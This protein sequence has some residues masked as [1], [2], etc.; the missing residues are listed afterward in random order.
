MSPTLIGAGAIIVVIIVFAIWKRFFKKS[1]KDDMKNV[2]ESE[3]SDSD[4][5]DVI[6]KA[7]EVI[8][9]NEEALNEAKKLIND[10]NS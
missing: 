7:E 10:N 8:K 6:S 5:K 4:R 2:V 9:K 3:A 1:V